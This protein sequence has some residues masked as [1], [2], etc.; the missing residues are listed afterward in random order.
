MNVHF[1][2]VRP[3]LGV[4]DYATYLKRLAALPHNP[5]LMIEHLT[6]AEEYALAK[7]HIFDV[8]KRIGLDF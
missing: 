3:G 1:E 4:L 6:S 7:R 8:G 5:P 2:E